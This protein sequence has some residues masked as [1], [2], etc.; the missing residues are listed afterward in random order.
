MLLWDEIHYELLRH[1]DRTQSFILENRDQLLLINSF[2][3]DDEYQ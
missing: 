3:W 2:F 1:T